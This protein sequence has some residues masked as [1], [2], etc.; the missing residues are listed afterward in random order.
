MPPGLPQGLKASF[1]APS[2]NSTGSDELVFFKPLP[3][4]GSRQ[5]KGPHVSGKRT[6]QHM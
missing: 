3:Q 2:G 4:I 5:E 6:V 1:Y